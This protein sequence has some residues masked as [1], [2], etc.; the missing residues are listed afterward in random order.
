MKRIGRFPGGFTLIEVMVAL[1]VFAI[2]AAALSRNASLGIQQTVRVEEQTLAWMVATNALNEI[3]IPSREL[4]R[5]F[6]TNREDYEVSAANREWQVEARFVTTQDPDLKR[7]E[8][9]VALSEDPDRIL[10]AIT[11][12]LG[13]Y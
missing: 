8:V 13:K 10:A 6:G 2:V 9:A 7:V 1:A 3:L 5:Y 11:G 12:F 4:G